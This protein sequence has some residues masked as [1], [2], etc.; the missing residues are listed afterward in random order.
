MGVTV[1]RERLAIRA[2]AGSTPLCRCHSIQHGVV[3]FGRNGRNR[4]DDPQKQFGV[5]YL[6]LS[7][8]GA[9]AETL[10]R[11]PTGQVLQKSDL[12]K[13]C[14]ARVQT[15]QALRLVH[16]HGEGLAQNGLDSQISSSADRNST[17]S[18]AREF[19]DHKDQPDGLIYRARHDD[20]QLS[21]ALFERASDKLCDPQQSVSWMNAGPLLDEVLDRYDIAL[22][23]A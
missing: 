11:K 8:N 7:P 2:I 21:I 4:F 9:F 3:Y 6:S 20:D 14:L 12:R 18:I 19:H 13:Y 15:R 16:C 17:Q 10:I 5:C 22:I 23:D 1:A